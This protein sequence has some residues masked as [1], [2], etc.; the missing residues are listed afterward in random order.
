MPHQI[1]RDMPASP[2]ARP[3]VLTVAGNDP[4]GG[5]GAQAD[6]KTFT[7]LNTYGMSVLTVATDCTTEGVTDLQPLPTDFV[8][9]QI[10]RVTDD[11][12]PQAT[13]TGLLFDADLIMAVSE[14]LERRDTGPL[15]VDPV[16]TTR[17]GEIL[18]SSDATAAMRDLVGQATVATPSHPEAEE[19]VDMDLQSRR[20]VERAARMIHAR[21]GPQHVVVTGG[22][23]QRGTAADLWFDGDTATWL[24]RT[25][26][27][28]AVHGA[29]DTFSA[30]VAVGLA[31]DWDVERS[32]RKAKNFA[33][34]AIRSAPNRGRGHRPL[35]HAEA[36][37]S[38]LAPD[39]TPP[40]S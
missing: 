22:H 32:V 26:Q 16:M 11:L 20:D 31:S 39:Q 9:R 27:P 14:V 37:K 33:T 12:P 10:E 36:T 35:A 40:D 28:Y 2:E 5:A 24:E 4:S 30:A 23:G 8:V 17:R 21:L 19:L 13:K 1:L 15:V 29:G 25:R 18:L 7:T 3:A 34:E 38:F 6:L